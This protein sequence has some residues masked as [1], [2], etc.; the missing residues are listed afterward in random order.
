MYSVIEEH[1]ER[2][3]GTIPQRDID[4]YDW[5]KKNR[6]QAGSPV[7]Q[8]NYRKYWAM[9]A[10][11]LGADFYAVYFGLLA[12]KDAGTIPLKVCC[13]RL[14]AASTRLNGSQ[15]IQFSFSTKLL[16]TANPR[17]PIYD[18]RVARFYFFREPSPDLAQTARIDAY[19]GFHDFLVR[20]YARVIDKRYLPESI[21]LFRSSFQAGDQTDEKI[22]DWLIWAF[23]GLADKGALLAGNIRYT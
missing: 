6:A 20:E 23:I 10:A 19:I 21:K 11:R 5:F 2:I 16:H 18:S 4:D 12:S 1:R 17:I 3:I 8:S 9:N 13:E 14:C 7:F 22:I 15:T